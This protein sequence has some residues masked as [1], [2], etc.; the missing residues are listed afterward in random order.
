MKLS[1]LSKN[2][3]VCCSFSEEA[4]EIAEQCIFLGFDESDGCYCVVD[5]YGR[6]WIIK[7][8]PEGCLAFPTSKE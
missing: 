8:I 4:Y 6:E 1:R 2:E 3:Y 5:D 7:P